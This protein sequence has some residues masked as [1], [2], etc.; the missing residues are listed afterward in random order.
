MGNKP[1]FISKPQESEL[2]M[3]IS[4]VCARVE[5]RVV[6]QS[7]P[8][9]PTSDSSWV[10]VPNH[11]PNGVSE[12][13]G[14][15]LGS[16]TFLQYL[17]AVLPIGKKVYSAFL[18]AAD[19]VPDQAYVRVGVETSDG[20]IKVDPDAGPSVDALG[21]PVKDR[22]T[23]IHYGRVLKRTFSANDEVGNVAGITSAGLGIILDQVSVPCGA[24]LGVSPETAAKGGEFGPFNPG[25]FG[26]RS[27]KGNNTLPSGAKVFVIQPFSLHR[28]LASDVAALLIALVN[29]QQSVPFELD[30]QS[31]AL[32]DYSDTWDFRGMNASQILSSLANNRRGTSW[33]CVY[34]ADPSPR[35]R[36]VFDSA[37]AGTT[38]ISIPPTPDDTLGAAYIVKPAANQQTLNLYPASRLPQNAD[39]RVTSC[40]LTQDARGCYDEIILVGGR[41][42]RTMAVEFK[43][44]KTGQLVKGWE[45]TDEALWDAAASFQSIQA[46]PQL[47]HVWR[48]FKF[49]GDWDGTDRGGSQISNYL[50]TS[51][52]EPFGPGSGETGEWGI[53]PYFNLVTGPFF[54]PLRMTGVWQGV[55]FNSAISQSDVDSLTAKQRQ[56]PPIPPFMALSD[57]LG[58][59]TPITGTT[60]EMSITVDQETGCIVLGNGPADALTIKAWAASGLRIVLTIGVGLPYPVRVSWR[61]SATP[62]RTLVLRTSSVES[63]LAPG[64]MLGIQNGVIKTNTNE[65]VL[66][67]CASRMRAVLGLMKLWYASQEQTLTYTISGLVSPYGDPNAPPPG[68]LITTA[69]LPQG[70]FT[71][72]QVV[73]RREWNFTG[74]PSVTITTA[75]V[76]PSIDSFL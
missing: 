47:D 50:T 6:I 11:I 20:E 4:P 71:L 64:T 9:W 26:N 59:Y 30:S 15:E 41:R 35:I 12:S 40:V 27:T 37:L 16:A 32:L 33:K 61:A 10:T 69:I 54:Q 68:V 49:R 39:H 51:S 63:T 57:G 60:N 14:N 43:S 38:P 52:I 17:G 13:L 24:V 3:P 45:D 58:N 56:Q 1:K 29:L 7:T 53:G 22:Y 73:T 31:K 65:L 36:I 74:V 67:R 23:A 25:G 21:N 28:W 42:M 66:E 44:D 76:L 2:L 55:N 46:S 62:S 72:N 5:Q 18:T 8:T 34:I 19:A 70:N 48:S 75:R